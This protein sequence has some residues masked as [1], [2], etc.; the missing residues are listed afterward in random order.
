[1]EEPHHT[2]LQTIGIKKF[3]DL[4]AADKRVEKVILL[5][6]RADNHKK[7]L[8]NVPIGYAMNRMAY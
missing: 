4:V 5:L 7:M 8:N 3:N 6:R 1:M 2:D